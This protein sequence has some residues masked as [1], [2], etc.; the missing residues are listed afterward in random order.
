M[1]LADQASVADLHD[2]TLIY[3]DLYDQPGRSFR[4]AVSEIASIEANL[5]IA[6]MDFEDFADSIGPDGV[7]RGFPS[8]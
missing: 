1:L 7:F 4:C 5:A 8:S 3:V 2:L 6:N